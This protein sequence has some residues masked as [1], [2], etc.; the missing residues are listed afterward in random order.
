MGVDLFGNLGVRRGLDAS[1]ADRDNLRLFRDLAFAGE[2]PADDGDVAQPRNL[3]DASDD[4][5][6]L[7]TFDDIFATLLS[8]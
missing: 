3:V 6:L 4:L 5:F 1:A 8:I 2:G 7:Q